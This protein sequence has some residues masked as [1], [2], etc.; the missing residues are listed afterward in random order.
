M[1]QQEGEDHNSLSAAWHAPYK[2]RVRPDGSNYHISS[3]DGN[4]V[5][6]HRKYVDTEFELLSNSK[7]GYIADTGSDELLG[8][9]RSDPGITMGDHAVADVP[10]EHNEEHQEP[11]G[12]SPAYEAPF[13]PRFSGDGVV[14]FVYFR[15]GH[16]LSQHRECLGFDL[17]VAE[18]LSNGYL[19]KQVS[20]E[21]LQRIRA[22]RGVTTV[23][24]DIR[25]LSME[26]HESDESDDASEIERRRTRTR[27]ELWCM[28]P[29]EDEE[30]ST[31]S[32]R[33]EPLGS[34]QDLRYMSGSPKLWN[35]YHV[36]FKLEH[37]F[38]DHVRY[39][40][41]TPQHIVVTGGYIAEGVSDDLF[42]NIYQDPG[43]EMIEGISNRRRS[44]L[45]SLAT[46]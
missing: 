23:K 42:L 19:V 18:E 39:L 22:D 45:L 30:S 9:I 32:G 38:V 4:T 25:W 31:S 13:E 10:L 37:T 12:P 20:D 43:V 41:L 29:S 40:G 24:D 1:S 15:E 11:G 7:H 8:R 35:V 26:P 46:V 28:D 6:E 17:E 36:T 33:E 14:Y 5:S 3:C 16:T 27:R 2:Q 21:L 34:Q 44:E